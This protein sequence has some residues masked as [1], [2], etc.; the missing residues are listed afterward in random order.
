MGIEIVKVA[1]LTWEA[2]GCGHRAVYV[3]RRG[4]R[5]ALDGDSMSEGQ[6][7]GGEMSERERRRIHGAG[8]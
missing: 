7:G 8:Q 2:E 6:G 3:C 5:C 1:E 4:T